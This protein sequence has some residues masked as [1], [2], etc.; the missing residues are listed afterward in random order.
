[1]AGVTEL[2]RR[3]QQQRWADAFAAALAQV[4]GDLRD[5]ADAGCRVAAQLLLYRDQVFAQKLEDF[6]SGGYG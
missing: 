3:Q 1:V 4:F 5:G 6:S 2:M